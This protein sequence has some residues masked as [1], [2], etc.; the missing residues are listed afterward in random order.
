M[1][2]V[3]P[4]KK[5]N[6]LKIKA[7][8]VWQFII[9]YVVTLGFYQFYWSYKA[10]FY[11]KEKKK[12]TLSPFWRTIFLQLFI[13][14]LYY[15]ICDLDHGKKNKKTKAAL[16][17]FLIWFFYFILLDLYHLPGYKMLW[18][19]LSLI[20]FSF[21]VYKFN[22]HAASVNKKELLLKKLSYRRI[23]GAALLF[24]FFYVLYSVFS[25]FISC[26]MHAN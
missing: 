21:V 5:G 19:L 1:G 2:A 26:W 15:H 13:G 10:W 3:I 8:P 25:I 4:E 17:S 12:L 14:F 11:I 22:K 23:V 20:P 18:Y 9:F 16:F 6:Y 7:V 24:I